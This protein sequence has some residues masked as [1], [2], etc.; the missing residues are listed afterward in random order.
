MTKSKIIKLEPNPQHFAD[1]PDE[2][3]AEMFESAIPV[4]H[5]HLFYEND[6]I[7]LYIGLWDTLD[8]TEKAGAYGCDEFMVL[9]E[10]QCEIKA[11]STGDNDLVSKGE[12]FII[13]K[14]YDCQWLQK[15]YLKKYFVISEHPNE[16]IP[17]APSYGGIIKPAAINKDNSFKD[18]KVE[19]FLFI[20][21]S[22]S[23]Q[24]SDVC[25]VNNNS[26]F[27]V[28]NWKSTA[29]KSI[30]APITMNLFVY[31]HQG[32]IEVVDEFGIKQTFSAEDAFFI[33]EA[34]IC[35][36]SSDDSV[37]LIYTAVKN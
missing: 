37:R 33:T 8:M 2:L 4:Q 25:Y 9:L 22:H 6:D 15:G 1:N 23:R 10:G 21:D 31:I 11:C 34:T 7:G 32:S 14:G 28:V 5:T 3:E 27:K 24:H 26:K 20:E 17:P 12:S 35:S 16:I 29:F 30:L 13:P 19:E 18:V 36:W